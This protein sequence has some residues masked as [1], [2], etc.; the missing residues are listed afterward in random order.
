MIQALAA[1]AAMHAATAAQQYDCALLPTSSIVQSAGVSLPLAGTFIGDY[2]ATAN[3]TG[4]R[5]LPGLFGGSGNQPI[6]YTSTISSG[7]T[8]DGTVPTGTFAL[9][10]DSTTG[11]VSV[12]G[13][14]LDALAGQSGDI[15]TD[16]SIGFGNFH[17]ASPT[18]TYFGVSNLT[19]PL[20]SGEITR[21]EA[22]QTGPAAGVATPNGD[23]TWAFALAVP[24]DT[25][26]EGAAFEQTFGGTPVPGVLALVGTLQPTK[27]GML[28]TVQASTSGEETL[29]SLG[30]IEGQP[31][32]LPTYLP[33]GGTAHLLV[34]GTFGEGTVS[35]SVDAQLVAFGEPTAI[36]GDL[37]GDG[38]VNGADLGLLLAAWGTPD[39]DLDGNGT[40]GGSDLGVLLANWAP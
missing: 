11:A 36:V 8:L 1:A 26:I 19:L 38:K 27:G 23:G 28:V 34:S 21:A 24:V 10:F 3:P 17:T 9:S 22:V 31:F 12:S 6:A 37:N 40:T 30:S 25:L 5:T 33:P 39:G 4:T 15:G 13:L 7:L 35:V 20:D 18:A 16:L 29:P 14:T 32:D 2:D